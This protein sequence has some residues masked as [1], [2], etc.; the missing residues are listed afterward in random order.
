MK[1]CELDVDLCVFILITSQG[2]V[3]L[4]VIRQANEDLNRSAD[5]CMKRIL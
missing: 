2:K 5:S 4:A 3:G 1:T